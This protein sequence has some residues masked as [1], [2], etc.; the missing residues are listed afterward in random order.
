MGGELR[1]KSRKTLRLEILEGREWLEVP[2]L[3]GTSKHNLI[4]II[5]DAEIV[6][7]FTKSL[8][9]RLARGYTSALI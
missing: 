3:L 2:L 6:K 1:V 8:A 4:C 9:E 5:N 7:N